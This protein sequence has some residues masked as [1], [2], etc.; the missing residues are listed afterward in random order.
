M[1]GGVHGL[2]RADI[3]AAQ[4]KA[5]GAVFK[6]EENIGKVVKEARETGSWEGARE[7]FE[8]LTMDLAKKV[9][10]IFSE[11]RLGEWEEK[12]R[13]IVERILSL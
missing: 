5:L 7:K 10:A 11:D 2:P 4:N 9:G 8:E 6:Y 3:L 13:P 1:C 12:Y